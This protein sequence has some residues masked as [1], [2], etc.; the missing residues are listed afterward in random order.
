MSLDSQCQG[1]L[2]GNSPRLN[3]SAEG[4]FEY[5]T[6][7]TP[8][9]YEPTPIRSNLAETLMNALGRDDRLRWTYVRRRWQGLDD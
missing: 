7:P 4:G 6:L 1:A 8:T 2:D 5:Q 3:F 9:R